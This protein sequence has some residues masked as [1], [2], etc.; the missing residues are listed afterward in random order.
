[1]SKITVKLCEQGDVFVKIGDDLVWSPFATLEDAQRKFVT[2]KG[3]AHL[4]GN[5]LVKI[6]LQ[7]SIDHLVEH[8]M[9]QD[10]MRQL[11]TADEYLIN[12][13]EMYAEVPRDR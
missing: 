11:S 2:Q 12:N 9:F 3:A 1:V 8:A 7:L 13:G 4:N 5:S 10:W 6:A